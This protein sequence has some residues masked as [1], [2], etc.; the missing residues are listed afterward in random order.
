MIDNRIYRI[1][2]SFNVE[3][4]LELAKVI[5][6][7]KFRFDYGSFQAE[8]KLHIFKNGIN[9]KKCV[10]ITTSRLSN[11]IIKDA[12]TAASSYLG[13]HGYTERLDVFCSMDI[14]TSEQILLTDYAKDRYIELSLFTPSII[15]AMKEEPVG[16]WFFTNYAENNDDNLIKVDEIT[17][18]LYRLVASGK[19]STDL[20]ASIINSAI[21]FSIFENNNAIEKLALKREVERK[22]RYDVPTFEASLNHLMLRKDVQKVGNGTN[23]LCLSDDV[24][25]NVKQAHHDAEIV[26]R[27]FN[28]GVI[29]VFEKYEV[30]N[31]ENCVE[32]LQ[33]LYR[34]HYT[35]SESL[36]TD[37]GMEI[38][39]DE[40]SDFVRKQMHNPHDVDV[41]M[42]EIRKLCADNPYLDQVTVSS[43]FITLYGNNK[44]SEYVN[45][46]Q[47]CVMLDTPPLVYYLCYLVLSISTNDW[48]NPA[49]VAMKSFVKL[50][51]SKRNEIVLCT[52]EDYVNEVIGEFRKALQLCCFEGRTDI[53]MLQQTRNTFFN[54]YLFLKRNQDLV[55]PGSEFKDFKGFARNCLRFKNTDIDSP[56]FENDSR[57]HI[58][59]ILKNENI[60]ILHRSF[61]QDL[62]ES[63]K[64][65]FAGSLEEGYNRSF[66]AISSD[67]RAMLLL[68]KDQPIEG[69]KM[70]EEEYD[71]YIATWDQHLYKYRKSLL[72]QPDHIDFR[73]HTPAKLVSKIGL[74]N[75]NIDA[76]CIS[77][78]ILVYANTT[79]DF[80]NKL[81]TFIDSLLP[82][83]SVKG[84]PNLRLYDELDKF[85][86]EQIGD[87]NAAIDEYDVDRKKSPTDVEEYILDLL[88]YLNNNIDEK[89]YLTIFAGDSVNIQF[90]QLLKS[91][92]IKILKGNKKDSVIT[93]L[94]K[95]IEKLAN[96]V[97]ASPTTKE[98]IIP[99]DE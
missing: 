5:E 82:L 74:E 34:Q 11:N 8:S 65:V 87:D 29:T 4:L 71:R 32:M 1:V 19:D 67:T 36:Q 99:L 90:S 40:F 23:L 60:T 53:D 73:I 91:G 61:D 77:G 57:I 6:K 13:I 17:K 16:D 78:N 62:F 14:P 93:E 46:R 58:Y 79:Y 33:Q 81:K 83:I 49:Y 98:I 59:K 42:A 2:S 89:T 47:K 69:L 35:F 12:I 21:V 96:S 27:N 38:T 55:E 41:L 64:K 72:K 56:A 80:R 7:F 95:K 70:R 44:L 43:A 88:K 28:E 75:F 3:K 97:A 52:I 51:K 92:Y 25:L 39:F 22:L 18:V 26:E 66:E 45:D 84:K 68:S 85:K 37:A 50:A 10:C 30:N 94:C 63:Q 24:Y 54:Y 15:A 9:R 76:S 31:R 48:D 86:S 20:K